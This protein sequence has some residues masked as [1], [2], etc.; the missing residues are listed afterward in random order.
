MSKMIF[1]VEDLN[2]ACENLKS[3][4]K[5][6]PGFDKMT[7]EA[8]SVW[9]KI[10]GVK[11]CKQ[12]NSGKYEP[13]PAQ[14]FTTAKMEGGYRSLAKLTAIDTI[15]QDVILE[16]LFAECEKRF[17]EHSH[18]YRKGRGTGTA[19]SAYCK[20]ATDFM[21]ASKTDL[22][23]CY[24]NI[25][26]M[27]LE[28]DLTEFFSS[29]KTVGLLMSYARMPVIT[30]GELRQRERGILQGAPISG[31][32]CNIYL[33]GLDMELEQQGIPFLRYADDI[34]I[35]AVNQS[36]IKKRTDE[37]HM[38][39]KENLLLDINK[40]KEKIDLSEKLVFLGYKFVRLDN[41]VV[42]ASSADKTQSIYYDWFTSKP[43]NHRSS[44][45]ILSDGIL[46]QKDYSALFESKLSSEIIPLAATKRIN[47]FSN[48][49]FDNGFL[50]YAL[51]SG[52]YINVF[53]R[54]Y[55]LKGRFTPNC[56]IK[57]Q[58]LIFE[59]LTAYNNTEKRLLLAKE[60]DLASVHNLK[61]NIRYHNKQHENDI[62][63]RALTVIDML[64]EKMKHCENYE[65]LLMI[66][67]QIRGLY[68]S[69]F[70][71][72]IQN[73][74]F[75]FYRR[76]KQ[77][78]LNEVNSLLSFGNVVLYNY[79]A[80]EVYKS[81]LDIRIGFLHATNKRMES[82]NLD[83]AEIFRPLIVDRIVFSVINRREIDTDCFSI[84]E[85]GGVY[86]NEDGKKV[87]LHRFYEKLNST[88][89]LNNRTCSYDM[90]IGMEIQKLV[91]CLRNGEKYRAFRQVR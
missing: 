91:R 18:A 67:A 66:E 76:S 10:N 42:P 31:M 52:V 49:V 39:I 75:S 40:A 72:F 77:P 15:V 30:D 14:G 53:G 63:N 51:S 89:R 90:L 41:E 70:D 61:L 9:L 65:H 86:L 16:K 11:L 50:D 27:I 83:I 79:I 12:L 45:D 23:S 47:V 29:K 7:A 87:F 88:I 20:Y 69:C 58:K 64:Q 13:L 57:D 71:S 32:L 46:R 26:H 81:S 5:F 74:E 48:V 6:S 43:K 56:S 21:F 62:F 59:Q 34:V 54:D 19:L 68:Y 38:L 35:F 33:H 22:K 55:S 85:N 8:A 17:S 80:T 25:D 37:L 44:V 84:L 78:P 1:S 3:K 2:R 36:E 82:L 73:K 28:K 60:F 4:K 24:D